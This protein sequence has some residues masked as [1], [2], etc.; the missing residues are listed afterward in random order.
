MTV[1]MTNQL[2]PYC[3]HASGLVDA[4]ID[5]FIDRLS[6]DE[7]AGVVA[8][9]VEQLRAEEEAGHVRITDPETDKKVVLHSM[10]H[11]KNQ[12]AKT[13][14]AF[15]FSHALTEAVFPL[16]GLVVA[17]LTT[18]HLGLSNLAEAGAALKAAWQSLAILH[19][20][21]DDD[22]IKA[23]RAI[24]T[25]CLQNKNNYLDI[26]PSNQALLASTGL[27]PAALGEA[28]K[29]L[30]SLKI[31]RNTAWGGQA[32]DYSHVDNTWRFRV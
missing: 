28:L 19:S 6:G 8:L 18:P 31:V 10:I 1:L 23:A 20:P 4:D 27:A 14:V 5:T 24:G 25:L 2:L 11:G 13:L 9:L 12:N 21:Q 30:Q 32:E 3:L 22:A 7:L 15:S 16:G 17:A 26:D 29:R